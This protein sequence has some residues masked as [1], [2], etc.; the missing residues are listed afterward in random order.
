ME[1]TQNL[2]HWI[3]LLNGRYWNSEWAATAEEAL[4]RATH[5]APFPASCYK[6]MPVEEWDAARARAHAEGRPLGLL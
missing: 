1:N 4:H 5:Q 3:S 2:K 6:V